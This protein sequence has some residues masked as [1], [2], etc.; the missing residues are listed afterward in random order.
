MVSINTAL[1][2]GMFSFH[3]K[4]SIFA[5]V[6]QNQ[7]AHEYLNLLNIFIIETAIY[8]KLSFFGTYQYDKI[9]LNYI[10]KLCCEFVSDLSGHPKYEPLCY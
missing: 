9:M 7:S 8:R 3:D 2:L 1:L 4:V 10:T 5:Q 6:I